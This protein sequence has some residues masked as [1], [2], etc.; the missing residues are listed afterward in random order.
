[1]PRGTSL[2]AD[3]RATILALRSEKLT[4]RV[5]ARRVHRS[6]KVVA[7][8]LRDPKSYGTKRRPGR[9][10]KLTDHDRR[11][12]AREVKQTGKGAIAVRNA[13]ALPVSKHT[14]LRELR[15]NPNLRYKKMKT[16][17]MLQDHHKLNRVSWAS[18][19]VTW[20]IEKWRTVVFSDEMKFNCDG[21]DGWAYYWH[22]LKNSERVFS[23]RQQGGGGV[24]TWACFSYHGKC[25][26]VFLEGRQDS[27]KY[28]STMGNHLLP[29][30]AITH[31]ENWVYQQDNCPIHVSSETKKWMA[32]QNINVLPWPSR[33]P[34]INPI[35]NLWAIVSRVV[36]RDSRQ[37]RNVRELKDAIINAWNSID[38]GTL[39]NLSDS[40]QRRCV[41]V[42]NSR[43]AKTRY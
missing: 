32:Q 20:S 3:E 29:W 4:T 42:L 24:M 25:D 18:C 8:F 43:G 12:I 17:F 19:H 26:I 40:M 11:R 10:K 22:H 27:K 9:P 21:P 13:L 37:F 38:D 34:D 15:S 7:S 30:A 5:I 36:Y 33:S 1:M 16:S 28:C 41:A 6:Q 39:Q 2:T 31:G 23:K 14:V 35:E